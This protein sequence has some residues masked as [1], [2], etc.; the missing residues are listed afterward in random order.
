MLNK[1]SKPK[2]PT[3]NHL[4]FLWEFSKPSICFL[5]LGTFIDSNVSINFK[6]TLFPIQVLFKFLNTDTEREREGNKATE[7]KEERG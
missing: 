4:K 7:R 3:T 1:E 6:T 2:R 5:F